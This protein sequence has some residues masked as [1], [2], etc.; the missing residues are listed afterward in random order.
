MIIEGK[1]SASLKVI[2]TSFNVICCL[3]DNIHKNSG[4]IGYHEDAEESQS[5]SD[6]Y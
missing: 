1:Q 6:N 5:Q 4:E 3:I 2:C